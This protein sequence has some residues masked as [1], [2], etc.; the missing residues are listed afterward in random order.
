MTASDQMKDT[1]RVIGRVIG[2]MPLTLIASGLAKNRSIRKTETTKRIVEVN[3]A[4]KNLFTSKAS[5]IGTVK[6]K[7]INSKS[8]IGY[9]LNRLYAPL[10]VITARGTGTVAYDVF[11]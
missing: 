11:G 7:I 1:T 8:L 9:S 5:E 2:H 4:L 10:R 3:T 6:V